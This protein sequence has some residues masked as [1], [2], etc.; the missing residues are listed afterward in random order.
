MIERPIALSP[1]PNNPT[2][3]SETRPNPRIARLAPAH[4]KKTP[5]SCQPL[6]R[7]LLFGSEVSRPGQ[8]FS[9]Q[10]SANQTAISWTMQ[11]QTRSFKRTVNQSKHLTPELSHTGPR[12]QA[13]PN[14]QPQ[15]CGARPCWLQRLVRYLQS[16]QSPIN[17][18]NKDQPSNRRK[19]IQKLLSRKPISDRTALG[20]QSASSSQTK[21]GTHLKR[22]RCQPEPVMRLGSLFKSRPQN[23]SQDNTQI[24]NAKAQPHGTKTPRPR[25]RNC[26][27]HPVLAAAIC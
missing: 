21:P 22:N 17:L 16:S 9:N 27:R 11:T 4:A 6:N 14:A 19:R 1:K 3:S 12:R 18:P 7:R 20:S 23:Q 5:I 15:T 2:R 24:P 26:Q 10:T 13:N 25:Q 8:I